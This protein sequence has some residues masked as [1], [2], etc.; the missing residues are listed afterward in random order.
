MPQQQ[1]HYH[2]LRDVDHT[3]GPIPNGPGT[4]D[5]SGGYGSDGGVDFEI[6]EDIHNVEYGADGAIAV[7]DND[8]KAVEVTWTLK[9]QSLAFRRL[10]ELAQAQKDARGL[11]PCP[12]FLVNPHSETEV[13][14]RYTIFTSIPG[15]NQ[16]K[17]MQELEISGVLPNARDQIDFSPAITG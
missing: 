12:F 10:M 8:V 4:V 11:P 13:R 5:I 9:A 16:V 15:P 3:V 17:N 1:P 14:D 6:V 2:A 7:S